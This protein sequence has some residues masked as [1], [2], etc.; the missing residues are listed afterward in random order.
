MD[1]FGFADLYQIHVGAGA[2]PPQIATGQVVSGNYYGALGLRPAAGRFITPE[3]DRPDAEPVAVISHAFWTARLGARRDIS[4]L[5]LRV[6]GVPT[7]V[8]G[9]GSGSMV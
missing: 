4:G 2:E 3:D 7:T 5:V 8:V 9:T 6:N 1:V